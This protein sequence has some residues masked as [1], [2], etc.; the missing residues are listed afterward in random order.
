MQDTGPVRNVLS[1]V[2]RSREGEVKM[3]PV[4]DIGKGSANP[5]IPLGHCSEVGKG[6]DLFDGKKTHTT[7]SSTYPEAAGCRSIFHYQGCAA[8]GAGYD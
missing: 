1:A 8:V 6:L 4:A 2:H 3:V 7:V 5:A